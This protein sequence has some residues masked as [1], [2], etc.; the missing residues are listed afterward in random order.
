MLT[1]RT[2]HGSRENAKEYYGTAAALWGITAAVYLACMGPQGMAD[3]GENIL[4]LSNYARKL[5]SRLKNVSI[6]FSAY[7]FKEFTVDFNKTG[8]TV[9]EINRALLER[10]VFGGK[11]LSGEFPALGQCALYCVTEIQNLESI[12]TLYSALQ[13]I[14]GR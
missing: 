1:K 2:S 7:T 4:Y 8:K 6:R 3:L 5:L 11:D 9:K 12:R 14:L 13:D 10:G